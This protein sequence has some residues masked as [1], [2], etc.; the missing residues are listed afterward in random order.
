M[1]TSGFAHV[2]SESRQTRQVSVADLEGGWGGGGGF[3]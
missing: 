1:F 3:T 2:E